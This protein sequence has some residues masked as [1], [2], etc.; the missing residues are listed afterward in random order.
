VSPIT[1]AAVSG[2]NL[3]SRACAIWLAVAAVVVVAGCSTREE[4]KNELKPPRVMTVSVIVTETRI[5]V[6]P[7]TFGAGP[8]RFV[9]SNKTDVKQRVSFEGERL[10]H[11]LTLGPGETD[12]FKADTYPGPIEIDGD[13]T[14]AEPVT[15]TVGPE[16]PTAQNDIEQP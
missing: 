10:S 1:C 13:H 7:G 5:G 4:Y 12:L 3:V 14:T 9:V 15:V 6:S 16:R 11:Q 2:R 8:T